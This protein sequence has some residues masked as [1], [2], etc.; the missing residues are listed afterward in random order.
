VSR[1]AFVVFG[2]TL[3][4]FLMAGYTGEGDDEHAV[5]GAGTS[6]VETTAT[7]APGE[8]NI[9]PEITREDITASMPVMRDGRRWF[10]VAGRGDEVL[11]SAE[12]DVPPVPGEPIPQGR[13]RYDQQFWLW[14]PAID[15]WRLAWT[16]G[17]DR[18]ESVHGVDGDWA[19]GYL[20]KNHPGHMWTLRLHNLVS[21]E[22]RE[23]ASL[24]PA[25]NGVDSAS[26]AAIGSG[27]VAFMRKLPGDDGV[28]IERVELYEIATGRATTLDEEGGE[29]WRPA[30]AGNMVSW[31]YSPPGATVRDLQ[32]YD[33]ATGATT[34]VASD[35]EH[36]WTD[37]VAGG[38]YIIG[39]SPGA[40]VQPR[41]T[42]RYFVRDL[43]GGPVTT[44]LQAALSV[45]GAK[46]GHVSWMG[47]GTPEDL[48]GYYDIGTNTLRILADGLPV[49]LQSSGV[50]DGW[51]WWIEPP[52]EDPYAMDGATLHVVRL[53]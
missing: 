13:A 19:L 28:L 20:Y 8:P 41:S 33:M 47:Q 1:T 12:R 35:G 39:E 29:H 4:L 25:A 45:F 51:F 38:Q 21:G 24:H 2:S 22:E 6:T 52:A 42:K 30:I 23:V 44:Y 15:E 46:G 50:V 40:I 10:V 49:R 18:S 37:V 34:V 14:N 27:H 43:V 31:Q 7:A 3:T 9:G 17:S 5:A 16:N 36:V 32:V 11:V 26:G 53:E 48:R